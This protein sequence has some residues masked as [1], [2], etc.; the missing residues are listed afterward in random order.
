MKDC[1]FC[2]LPESRIKK[3]T[4]NF[5]VILDLYPISEGHTLIIPKKHIQFLR[6]LKENAITELFNLI[7]ELQNEMIETYKCQDFNIGINEGI[8]AGQTIQHLHIHIIPRYK[9]DIDDPRGG[10][11]WIIP[12][13]AKYWD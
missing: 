3:Q 11:R 6:N 12:D 9:G 1:I 5:N 10:V 7:I 4:E 2:S 8:L 13:K